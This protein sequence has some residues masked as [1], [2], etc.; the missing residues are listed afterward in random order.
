MRE[1]WEG[2]KGSGGGVSEGHHLATITCF[3]WLVLFFFF[4][5]KDLIYSS[6]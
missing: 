5:I 3:G 1:R 2:R 4:S 6:I